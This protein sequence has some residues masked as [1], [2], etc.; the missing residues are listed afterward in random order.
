MSSQ[1]GTAAIE[2]VQ[3][4]ISDVISNYISRDQFAIVPSFLGAIGFSP[5]R[6]TQVLLNIG[7]EN[8]EGTDILNPETG[9]QLYSATT[10][11]LMSN[12]GL[13]LSRIEIRH[14]MSPSVSGVR[15]LLEMLRPLSVYT[16]QDEVLTF[17]FTVFTFG[18]YA[19]RVTLIGYFN[20][21]DD[22]FVVHEV[23]GRTN[24][25]GLYAGTANEFKQIIRSISEFVEQD[26]IEIDFRFTFHPDVMETLS[27]DWAWFH[28]I[29]YYC[30]QTDS[31]FIG[32]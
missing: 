30:R 32:D 21:Q 25:P 28:D 9:L 29:K 12:W 18:T 2:I 20:L 13:G 14:P 23:Q 27:V 16:R 26:K 17:S 4:D 7:F 8:I 24:H 10:Q 6:S 22:S 31:F 3:E 1:V 15:N 19:N 5:S 11:S